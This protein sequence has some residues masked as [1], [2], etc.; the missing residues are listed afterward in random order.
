MGKEEGVG[1]RGG[2]GQGNHGSSVTWR[3]RVSRGGG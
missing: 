3:E 2:N 1:A